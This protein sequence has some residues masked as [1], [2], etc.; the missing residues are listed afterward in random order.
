MSARPPDGT[1]P[2]P[3]MAFSWPSPSPMA[4]APD[5]KRNVR[6]CFRPAATARS[7]APIDPRSP[8]AQDIDD[9][10]S[11]DADYTSR[12]TP[13]R[14]RR[15]LRRLRV[16][17]S[18]R[19]GSKR[20]S[21]PKPHGQDPPTTSHTP[22]I[23]PWSRVFYARGAPY[24]VAHRLERIDPM[25][26]IKRAGSDVRKL[27]RSLANAATTSLK[28]NELAL[29]SGRV[30]ARRTALGVAALF[31]PA[32]SDHIEFSRMVPEKFAAFAAVSSVVQQRSTAMI[33][34][35]VG[36]VAREGTIALRAAGEIAHFAHAGRHG[37][38]A[39]PFCPRMVRARP[40]PVARPGLSRPQA[41]A[42]S[43]LG[44]VHRAATGN[45]RR[46]HR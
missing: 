19:V 11:V 1:R 44:P 20:R 42:V 6:T 25:T 40:L 28:G 13:P 10:G 18:C 27:T 37:R 4:S 2:S 7:A 21:R 12:Q 5:F 9:G 16:T 31:D 15:L 34:Q 41:R 3:R 36:F 38:G 39:E 33:G 43:C 17:S 32:N 22:R 45:A 30:I 26:K 8:E 29:A 35:M 24:S 23:I 46:L 14:L